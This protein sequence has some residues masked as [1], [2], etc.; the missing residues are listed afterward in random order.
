MELYQKV[1][2]EE[3]LRQQ[4]TKLELD[5]AALVEMKCYQAICRIYEILGDEALE[6][7]D[8]FARIEQIVCAMEELGVGGNC[9]HDF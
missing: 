5:E 8:C 3:L 2:L 4:V 9:R 7:S 6:D 1:L